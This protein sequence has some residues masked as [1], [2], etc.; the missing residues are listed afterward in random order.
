MK[1]FTLLFAGFCLLFLNTAFAGK[2]ACKP[3]LNKLHNIQAQQKVGHSAK[4]SRKLAERESKARDTWW[5]C[6]QGKLT[7]KKKKRK[8]KKSSKK[9]SVKQ[10]NHVSKWLNTPSKSMTNKLVLKAKYQGQKQQDWLDYYQQ[11]KQC[12]RPKTTQVFAYCL[13][14]EKQQQRK[15]ETR[16]F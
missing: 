4:Q 12:R 13:E 7:S 3:Y 10:G 8:S 6:Q 15:F 14:D 1:K 16:V 11:P 2:K 9:K 5:Q